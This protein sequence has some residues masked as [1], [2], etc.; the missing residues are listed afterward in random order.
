M[1]IDRYVELIQGLP[2]RLVDIL[3]RILAAING[4][5]QFGSPSSGALNVA[6]FWKTGT[7]PGV[8]DQEFTITHNLG[9]IPSGFIQISVDQS[10][11]IYKGVSTWTTTQIFLKCHQTTVN[12][13]LFIL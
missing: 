12:Y 13:T 10:A 5:I 6:G 8:A 7:T 4:G 3:N 11:T 2:V 9:Y 1:I